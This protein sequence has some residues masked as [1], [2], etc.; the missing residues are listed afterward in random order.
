MPRMNLRSSLVAIMFGA[1]TTAHADPLPTRN[2]N[3]LLGGFG[4]PVAMPA[5]LAADRAWSFATDFNWASTALVQRNERESL[6]VDAETQEWRITLQRAVYER[7]AFQLQVPYR[8]TSGGSLDGFI[9]DW[10]D[11]FSLPEGIRPLLPEDQ[12]AIAYVRNGERAFQLSSAA[13]GVGDIAAS[14]GYALHA[15]DASSLTAWLSAELPTGNAKELTGNEAFDVSAILTGERRVGQR[16]QLYGQASVTWLGE[17]KVLRKQQR[18]FVLGGV[19]GVSWRVVQPV[20]LK[21]QM[22]AHTAAFDESALD[23]LNEALV[24][25]IGGAL[26][27]RSGWRLELSVSEDIA[28]ETAPDVVF[29]LGVKRDSAPQA[30]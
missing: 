14:L 11:F 18:D 30:E 1:C 7:F 25:S 5:T 9:D 17:G 4:V 23:F 21:L 20:E 10:H 2:Q 13:E 16:A 8:R 24:L 15:S 22:D 19:A 28:V 12:L 27:F 26:H 3:P 29:V 6:I